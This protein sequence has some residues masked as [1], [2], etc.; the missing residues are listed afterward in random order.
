M[1]STGQLVFSR[2]LNDSTHLGIRLLVIRLKSFDT[3][4]CVLSS[5]GGRTDLPPVVGLDAR[6]NFEY[7]FKGGHGVCMGLDVRDSGR[8]K[9]EQDG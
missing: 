1:I 6:S 7:G 8:S 9:G 3:S 5:Q 2:K 4:L